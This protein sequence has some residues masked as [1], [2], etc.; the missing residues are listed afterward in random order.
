MSL[1]EQLLEKKDLD[2]YLRLRIR[3][4][5]QE[6]TE[7]LTNYPE[8]ERSKVIATTRARIKELSK[9]WNALRSN[10]IRNKSK[11]MWRHFNY[12]NNS[13]V[14][15]DEGVASR[16]SHLEPRSIEEED[17]NKLKCKTKDADNQPDA[18]ISNGYKCGHET[19]GMIILDDNELSLSVYIDWAEEENNLETMNECF[20]C[21][22]KRVHPTEKDDL[23]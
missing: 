16:I 8:K 1:L 10:N 20:D 4:L 5:K 22:L 11:Q 12:P 6:I 14:K 15:K 2:T 21:Y 3:R 7:R 23:K 9:L 18:V 19:H 13:Q 17:N